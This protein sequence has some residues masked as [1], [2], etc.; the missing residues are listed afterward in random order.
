MARSN[1]Y[2]GGLLPGYQQIWKSC[3]PSMGTGPQQALKRKVGGPPSGSPKQKKPKPVAAVPGVAVPVVARGKG[4][5]SDMHS[6]AGKADVDAT[7][8][9]AE[10]AGDEPTPA[11]EV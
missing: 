8:I 7:A 5:T 11:A 3:D 1:G 9:A 4:K 2:N 6:A 10:A